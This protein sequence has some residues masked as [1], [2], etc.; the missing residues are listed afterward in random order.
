MPGEIGRVAIPGEARPN[1]K[2]IGQFALN[3]VATA[4]PGGALTLATV[5][6]RT[7]EHSAIYCRCPE[8]R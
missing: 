7:D 5:A 2:A 8:A 4:G 3:A 6:Q 1:G